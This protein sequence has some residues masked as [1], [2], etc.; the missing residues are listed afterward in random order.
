MAPAIVPPE[1]PDFLDTT[2]LGDE[3]PDA[4]VAEDE[5]APEKVD[6]LL[7]GEDKLPA[8]AVRVAAVDG[9]S[10]TGLEADDDT[11]EARALTVS[12]PHC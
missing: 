1:I 7:V 10:V 6:G 5:D 12:F 3:L 4:E 11:D 8:E 9:P 2:L